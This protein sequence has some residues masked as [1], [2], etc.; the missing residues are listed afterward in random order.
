M[1][2]YVKS[3]RMFVLWLL[4]LSFIMAIFIIFIQASQQQKSL[5]KFKEHLA[6]F[7]KNFN[8]LEKEHNAK[9]NDKA[10]ESKIMRSELKSQLKCKNQPLQIQMV[11]HGDYWV[12]QNLIRGRRSSKMECWESITYTTVAD[13]TY[14]HHLATVVKRWMGP[15]SLALF[16][17]GYDFEDAMASIQYVRN[18]L[19]ESQLIR[20][21]VSFHLF[22]HSDDLPYEKVPSTEEEAL[23]WE[24]DCQKLDEFY[25]N[26]DHNDMYM[27]RANLSFPINVGRNIA[28]QAANTHFI[29][30]SDIE[31]YPSLDFINQFLDMAANNYNLIMNSESPSVFAL[32]VFELR[33]NATLPGNKKELMAMLKTGEAMPIYSQFG[34]RSF[35]LPEQHKWVQAHT[36][37]KL[38]VLMS[39][40]RYGH[41]AYWE[42][43]FV[44]NNREPIYDERLALETGASRRALHYAMCVLDYNYHVLHP[45]FLVHAPGDQNYEDDDDEDEEDHGPNNEDE[46]DEYTEELF[47]QNILPNYSILYGERK[48]CQI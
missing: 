46:Y 29:M 37:Q 1:I 11:Q 22:F 31:L 12:M 13:F 19:P 39:R 6:Y 4:L 28:R 25:D 17:P 35:I 36:P 48:S 27:E 26:L 24:Y 2:Q 18:C 40:K 30:S 38:E 14:M 9:I 7:G 47:Q 20:N 16:A 41:Y 15:V 43:F 42:P 5:P 21:Y 34:K 32:P 3:R 8:T 33:E 10:V 44:S 45:A 23:N